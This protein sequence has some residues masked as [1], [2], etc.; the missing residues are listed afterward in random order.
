[1]QPSAEL[2]DFM[3]RFFQAAAD[4]D[5]ASI[6]RAYSREPGTLQIG[7][8]PTE[9]WHGWEAITGIWGRQIEALGGGMPVVAHDVEAWQEGNAGWV[10]ANGAVRVE[11]QPDLPLR[12]TAVLRRESGGWKIVQ[13]HGSIGVANEETAFGD[14][15]A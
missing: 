4:G 9:W 3:L 1:M 6:E 5:T 15:P 14:V 12:F 8:D 13:G 10:A 2:R 11:G 7:T